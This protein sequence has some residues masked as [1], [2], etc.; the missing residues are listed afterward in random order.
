MRGFWI[1]LTVVVLGMGGCDAFGGDSGQDDA[2]AGITLKIVVEWDG[3]ASPAFD[4]AGVEVAHISL[5]TVVNGQMGDEVTDQEIPHPDPD[6]PSTVEVPGLEP[7]GRYQ[8]VA[9]MSSE[10]EFA[11]VLGST[12]FDLTLGEEDGQEVTITPAGPAAAIVAADEIIVMVE[13]GMGSF[14][15]WALNGEGQHLLVPSNGWTS[16]SDDPA[17]C[18]A[19]EGTFVATI[20]APNVM[21]EVHFG[22]GDA[23]VAVPCGSKANRFFEPPV[24][25]FGRWESGPGPSPVAY[26]ISNEW[27]KYFE[28]EGEGNYKDW[29]LKKEWSPANG[30]IVAISSSGLAFACRDGRVERWFLAQ[31]SGSSMSLSVDSGKLGVLSHPQE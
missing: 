22:V 25:V 20:A 7:G 24:E 6:A 5:W 13:G 16:W 29:V 14:R 15:A 26:D 27:I 3:G 31:G 4:T 11:T 19:W 28:W 8:V 9:V 30:D 18:P 17:V 12:H 2:P 23:D 1:P 21:T 10:G